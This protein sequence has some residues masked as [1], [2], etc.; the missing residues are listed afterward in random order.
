MSMMFCGC[1]VENLALTSF[2]TRYVEGMIGM[3]MDC[4]LL[5]FLDISNF[6]TNNLRYS[7]NFIDG[8]SELRLLWTNRAVSRIVST[9]KPKK[10]ERCRPRS[11]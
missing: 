4:P 10:K 6:Q 5:K 9:Q 3:F 1:G 2:D 8:C 7:A 11:F